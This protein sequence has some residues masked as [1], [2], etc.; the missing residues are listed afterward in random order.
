M[1][2]IKELFLH[3]EHIILAHEHLSL[4]GH[5]CEYRGRRGSYGLV[6][7]LEGDGEYR[8]ADGE[9]CCVSEGDTILLSADTAYILTPR[10]SFR[11]YTV[12]FT[13]EEEKSH[14]P[15][16]QHGF[17]RLSVRNERFRSIFCELVALQGRRRAE[18][19]MGRRGLLYSLL[20]LFVSFLSEDAQAEKSIRLMPA[21]RYIEENCCREV[22]L[23]KLASLCHMSITAFRRCWRDAYG[24]TAMHYRDRLRIARATEFLYAGHFSVSEI[25]EHCGFEDV[26]YFVKFFKRQTGT[27]P[28]HFG[29]KNKFSTLSID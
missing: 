21:K 13:V 5:K 2:E 4:P 20:S 27:T 16:T 17:L 14:F 19:E 18:D 22:N 8:F 28:G 7:V 12:N 10:T 26:S 15:L 1:S 29:E 9:R 24:E 23:T 11:H 6:F 3:V 25:A